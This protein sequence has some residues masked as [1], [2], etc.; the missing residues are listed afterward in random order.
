MFY[1]QYF[2]IIEATLQLTYSHTT[3]QQDCHVEADS[4]CWYVELYCFQ[5]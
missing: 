4:K 1:T 3:F 2:A 5:L